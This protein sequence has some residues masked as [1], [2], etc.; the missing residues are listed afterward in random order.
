MLGDPAYGLGPQAHV[1]HPREFRADLLRLNLPDAHIYGLALALLELEED[2]RDV[3]VRRI[4]EPRLRTQ[5]R[6]SL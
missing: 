2:G 6:C 3:P 4:E 1:S 5:L